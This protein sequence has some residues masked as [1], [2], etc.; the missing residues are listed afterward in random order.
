MRKKPLDVFAC[1]LNCPMIVF[2]PG[3]LFRLNNLQLDPMCANVR[4]PVINLIIWL[5]LV[6]PNGTELELNFTFVWRLLKQQIGNPKLHQIKKKV[7]IS[8]ELKPAKQDEN[9]IASDCFIVSIQC[10]INLSVCVFIF[11]QQKNVVLKRKMMLF[12]CSWLKQHIF[13]KNVAATGNLMRLII[14]GF[15]ITWNE[16]H[17]KW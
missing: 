10:S 17:V 4:S 12:F 6:C 13:G 9:S 3:K 16:M 14:W 5:N 11:V 1:Y 8:W 2:S 7:S 15:K